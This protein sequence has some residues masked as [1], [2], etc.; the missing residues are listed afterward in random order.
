M[1]EDLIEM[2]YGRGGMRILCRNAD[3][4]AAAE[5]IKT[6]SAAEGK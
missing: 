3:Q 5:K 1:D 2:Y 4:Q 6:Y